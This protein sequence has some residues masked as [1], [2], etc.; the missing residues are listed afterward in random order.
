MKE[1]ITFSEAKSM[2]EVYRTYIKENL[3]DIYDISAQDL[4]LLI[5]VVGGDGI[6]NK[7]NPKTQEGFN[8]RLEYLNQTLEDY[9]D[10]RKILSKSGKNPAYKNKSM[11]LIRRN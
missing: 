3:E 1:E 9:E 8:N 5:K 2:E 11:D 10:F 6:W 4:G 7:S